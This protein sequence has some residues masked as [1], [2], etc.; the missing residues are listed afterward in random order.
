MHMD[1]LKFKNYIKNNNN[2]LNKQIKKDL[3]ISNKQEEK[4]QNL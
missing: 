2:K 4:K 3:F 1:V